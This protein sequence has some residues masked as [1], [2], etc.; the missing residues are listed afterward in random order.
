MPPSDVVVPHKNVEILKNFDNNI[1]T[2]PY[3]IGLMQKR[4]DNAITSHPLPSTG[5]WLKY[6]VGTIFKKVKWFAD[7]LLDSSL[8]VPQ[9]LSPLASRWGF[10]PDLAGR[11]AQAEGNLQKLC[12]ECATNEPLKETFEFWWREVPLYRMG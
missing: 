10:S 7:D 2:L 1:N 12:M 5:H 9:F 11:L 3:G 8:V 6:G 4:K